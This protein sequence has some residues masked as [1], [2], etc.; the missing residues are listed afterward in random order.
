MG[1]KMVLTIRTNGIQTG[2]FEEDVKSILDKDT[3]Q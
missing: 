1:D 3:A 2:L